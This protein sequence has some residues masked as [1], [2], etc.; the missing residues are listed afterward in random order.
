M[1]RNKL[2]TL[3]LLLGFNYRSKRYL[4]YAKD[5]MKE[6]DAE[7]LDQLQVLMDSTR[8]D[9]KSLAKKTLAKTKGINTT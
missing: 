9:M 1:K 2:I 4:Y 7:F 5:R 6:K 8:L 3:T